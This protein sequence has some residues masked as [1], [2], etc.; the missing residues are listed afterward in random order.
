MLNCCLCRFLS[1]VE[2][3]NVVVVQYIYTLSEMHFI[4]ISDNGYH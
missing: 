4:Y 1:V 3:L 2:A